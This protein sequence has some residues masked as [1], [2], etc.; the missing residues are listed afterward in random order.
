[1]N[2]LSNNFDVVVGTRN[3][4][5]API[6]NLDLILIWDDSNENFYSPQSPYWNARD[7]AIERAKNEGIDISMPI[8]MEGWN[9]RWEAVPDEFKDNPEFNIYKTASEAGKAIN[10]TWIDEDQRNPDNFLFYLLYGLGKTT[11]FLYFPT[12]RE[13]PEFWK[14]AINNFD[15]VKNLILRE[16]DLFHYDIPDDFDEDEDDYEDYPYVLLEDDINE[17]K[18]GEKTFS[19][20]QYIENIY[21]NERISR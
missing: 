18:V 4:I 1:M 7:V 13:N 10:R 12:I 11:R 15:N 8:T 17:Y 20:S 2:I 9:D 3:A 21:K 6:D 19:I 14:F 5:F 16:T